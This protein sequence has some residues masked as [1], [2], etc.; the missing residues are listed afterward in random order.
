MVVVEELLGLPPKTA[1]RPDYIQPRFLGGL[2]VSDTTLI[3]RVF[4][5]P[6]SERS[7]EPV[8]AGMD[9]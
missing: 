6:A 4:D 1:V 3:R 8:L 5:F 9:R 7:M 2:L